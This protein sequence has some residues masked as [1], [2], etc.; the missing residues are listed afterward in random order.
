MAFF[1]DP[2][3]MFLGCLGTAERLDRLQPALYPNMVY[4][5]TL[6]IQCRGR[7]QAACSVH[8]ESHTIVWLFF[9]AN[10]LRK[11]VRCNGVL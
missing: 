5:S 6:R 10:F 11:E 1:R 3:E 2:G 8:R 9:V 7:A 4:S